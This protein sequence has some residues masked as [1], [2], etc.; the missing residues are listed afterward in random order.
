MAKMLKYPALIFFILAIIYFGG[1]EFY[2]NQATINSNSFPVQLSNKQNNEKG[3][4]QNKEIFETYLDDGWSLVWN[5]EF[6]NP[7]LDQA[8]WN[9]ENWAAEKNEEL[10]FYTPGNVKVQDG[11]L[12]LISEMEKYQGRN[13]TSG[14]IHSKDKFFFEYGKVE[15]RAKLPH[16]KGIF[17]AFWMMPNQDNVWLPEIDILEML[18]HEPDR[19]W[20]VQHQLDE[21]GNLQS[22]SNSF[23]GADYSKDFHLFGIEWTPSEIVWLIDGKEQ[24]RTNTFQSPGNMYLYINTAVGGVWPGN[25]DASTIFPQSFF[26]DYVR[27]FQ[28]IGEIR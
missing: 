27:V 3:F 9:I 1:K 4:I 11:K 6:D 22:E 21:N 23:K 24:F 26:V 15:I 5:D 19:I 13:Y 25:P 7:Q 28:R 8:K 18:G 12:E 17:P 2:M 14:A 10:Q 20:M 16:G